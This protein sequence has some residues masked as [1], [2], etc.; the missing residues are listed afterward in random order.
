[1]IEV[2]AVVLGVI[3][4]TGF[5]FIMIGYGTKVT[6]QDSQVPMDYIEQHNKTPRRG[7]R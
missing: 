6:K 1:M 2:A 4:I 5:G 7:I 3:M